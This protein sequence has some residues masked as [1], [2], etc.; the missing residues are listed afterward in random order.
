[1]GLALSLFLA[2]FAFDSFDGRPLAVT[3]PALALHLLP[4]A[5]VAVVVAAAWRHP[6]VGVVA[7]AMLAIGYAAWVPHRLDWI[8][9]ISGPLALTAALHAMSA[10][11]DSQDRDGQRAIS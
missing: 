5:I 10:Q 3:L 11:A 1:M 2:L 4:A 6:L 7:F 8:L 9:V